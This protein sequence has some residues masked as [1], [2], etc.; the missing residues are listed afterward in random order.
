MST[1]S[2]GSDETT[3]W[4]SGEKISRTSI[5]LVIQKLEARKKL[6]KTFQA[7]LN[8]ISATK[9]KCPTDYGASMHGQTNHIKTTRSTR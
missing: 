4:F 6:T 2:L 8:V 7:T 1:A 9:S 5:L 3:A